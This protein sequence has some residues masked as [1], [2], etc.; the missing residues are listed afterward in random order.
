MLKLGAIFKDQMVLQQMSEA[1]V[2]GETDCEKVEVVFD[3]EGVLAK[4]EQGRFL[5]VI[6][7]KQAGEK[8]YELVVNGT[9]RSGDTEQIVIHD[10]VLGEVWLA[11]GQSN[12]ELELQNSD[13]GARVVGEADYDFIRFYNVPKCPAVDNNLFEAE[14]GTAW[15]KVKDNNPTDMSAVA[16][17]F[18]KKLYEE[19]KVPIGIIDCYWGGTSATCWVNRESLS[20]VEEVK[21]YINEWDAICENKTDEEYDKEQE[22]WP[23]DGEMEKWR[24]GE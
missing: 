23:V 18:A 11:G 20:D 4:I 9:G 10:V 14:K 8:S 3:G 21:P 2:F 1:A 16:Y 22:P 12:M 6:H 13:N 5:A 17:Y 7:T 15:K 24:N 19:I